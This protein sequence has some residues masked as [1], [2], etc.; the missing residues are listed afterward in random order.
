V[1]LNAICVHL[2]QHLKKSTSRVAFVS[3]EG[4]GLTAAPSNMSEL[5]FDKIDDVQKSPLTSSQLAVVVTSYDKTIGTSS[6]SI[7]ITIRNVDTHRSKRI[8]LRLSILIFLYRNASVS[9]KKSSSCPSNERN[10]K[11]NASHWKQ[12]V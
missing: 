6:T 10:W 5:K 9:W 1:P 2:G 7:I 4:Q 11:H 8:K 3:S 12:K